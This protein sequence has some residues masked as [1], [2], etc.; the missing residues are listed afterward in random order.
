MIC[1]AG[2]QAGISAHPTVFSNDLADVN[3]KEQPGRWRSE[4]H[5]PVGRQGERVLPK[6]LVG[7][8]VGQSG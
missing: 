4:G 5:S 3:I 6:T 2:G 8:G 7:K 1:G